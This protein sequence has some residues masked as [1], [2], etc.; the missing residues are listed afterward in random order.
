MSS[1][2][3]QEVLHLLCKIVDWY[4]GT[5]T[6]GHFLTAVLSN[7]LRQACFRADLCNRRNLYV[8]AYFLEN[9][10]P[11]DWAEKANAL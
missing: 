5:V 11:L 7:N 10:M 1:D 9:M 3:F 4:N 2:D 6:P 8:Y